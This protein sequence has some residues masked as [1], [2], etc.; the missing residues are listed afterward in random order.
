MTPRE[1]ASPK[2]YGTF[3]VTRQ[4]F[5]LINTEGSHCSDVTLK[6]LCLATP[7]PTPFPPP[8]SDLMRVL[9]FCTC[10]CG[11]EV[12][13]GHGIRPEPGEAGRGVSIEGGIMILCLGP[14]ATDGVPLNWLLPGAGAEGEAAG[15]VR[16]S[17]AW[18]N[19]APVDE[20]PP[21]PPL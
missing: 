11:F 1:H 18:G 15:E 19:W 4:P 5:L 13:P 17:D 16:G 6:S 2:M 12:S 21:A 20:S 10:T 3:G 14:G 7:L 8:S 9:P